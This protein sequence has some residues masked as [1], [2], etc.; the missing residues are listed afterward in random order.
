MAILEQFLRLLELLERV[1]DFTHFLTTDTG[2]TI[3]F[4][5]LCY[6]GLLLTE[7]NA[8]TASILASTTALTL[9]CTLHHP[10]F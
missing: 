5:L 9:Y 6:Q 3:G 1:A 10:K 7:C 4:C 8:P 2:L